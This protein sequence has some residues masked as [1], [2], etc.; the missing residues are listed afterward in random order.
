LQG[1][2]PTEFLQLVDALRHYFTFHPQG[3]S[4]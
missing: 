1:Q 2:A 4:A 3:S